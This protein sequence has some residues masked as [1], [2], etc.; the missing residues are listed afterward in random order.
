MSRL[1]ETDLERQLEKAFNYRGHV[2][3][4]LDDGSTVEGYVFNR[5]LGHA[6]LK[7]PPF[8]ELFRKGSGA[9]EKVALARVRAIALSGIDHAAIAP[10][11]PSL[12]K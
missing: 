8:V 12:K 7:E 10:P 4:T 9:K 5:E 2:T 11:P 3:L 1:P 6:K